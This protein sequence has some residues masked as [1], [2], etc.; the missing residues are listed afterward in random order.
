[1]AGK[2]VSECSTLVDVEQVKSCEMMAW[3]NVKMDRREEGYEKKRRMA[4]GGV[5]A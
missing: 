1:M 2:V 3:C 5:E 4:F